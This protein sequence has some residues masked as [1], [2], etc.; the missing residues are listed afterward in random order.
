[1]EDDKISPVAQTR[2]E[3]EERSQFGGQIGSLTAVLT[4]MLTFWRLLPLSVGSANTVTLKSQFYIATHGAEIAAVAPLSQTN[5]ITAVR[6]E[7]QN[8]RNANLSCMT[9]DAHDVNLVIDSSPAL[10]FRT[11]RQLENVVVKVFILNAAAGLEIQRELI[12]HREPAESEVKKGLVACLLFT[13]V[14]VAQI[15][16]EKNA[17]HDAAEFQTRTARQQNVLRRR[18]R[19]C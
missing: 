8:I 9:H 15:N 5:L 4:G 1:M 3:D 13:G 17:L 6:E 18:R 12:G 14:R 7:G 11:L 19:N 2:S 16:T 10:D